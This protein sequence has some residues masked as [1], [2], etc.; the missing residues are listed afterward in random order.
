LLLEGKQITID[1]GAASRNKVRSCN[2]QSPMPAEG[3]DTFFLGHL[4]R[5]VEIQDIHRAFRGCDIANVRWCEKN[6]TF[7]G[8]AFVQFSSAEEAEKA[9]KRI[10][11]AGCIVA[12]KTSVVDWASTAPTSKQAYDTEE[13]Q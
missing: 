8:C 10:L 9:A 1:Y 13:K 4:A 12:G 11:R 6:G 5:T 2:F 3:T 7:S